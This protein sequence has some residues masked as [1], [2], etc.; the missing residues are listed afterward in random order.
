[1]VR[2]L[3]D[4]NLNHRILRGLKLR[5][6]DLDYVVVQNTQ[7]RG[8]QDATLLAWAAEQNRILVTHD[9]KSVP[10]LAYDRVRAGQAMPGVVTIPK[11]LA[12]G[13]A[14]EELATLIECC[15][16]SDLQNLVTYLPL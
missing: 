5:F 15:E 6:P 3:I 7:L 16:Q 9:I 12:I 13:R 8:V 10:R 11:A 14:I 4:E 1:M 2:L